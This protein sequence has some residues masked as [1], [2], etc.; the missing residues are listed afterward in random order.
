MNLKKS[1]DVA[2]ALTDTD[3]TQYAT[4]LQRSYPAACRYAAGEAVSVDSLQAASELFGMP[5]SAFIK[6]GEEA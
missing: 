1:Y 6:L 4:V 3:R 5:V 2:F